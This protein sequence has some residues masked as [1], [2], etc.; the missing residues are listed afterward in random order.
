[1]HRFVLQQIET[2][3]VLALLDMFWSFY[4]S[5]YCIFIYYY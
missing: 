2:S 5:Y 3:G 4:R 1:L